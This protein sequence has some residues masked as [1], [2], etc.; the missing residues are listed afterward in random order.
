MTSS[1][2]EPANFR[3]LAQYLSQ[4]CH[5]MSLVL[6]FEQREGVLSFDDCLAGCGP[7]AQPEKYEQKLLIGS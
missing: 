4:M 2:I 5:K 7:E 1:G 6:T 3:V